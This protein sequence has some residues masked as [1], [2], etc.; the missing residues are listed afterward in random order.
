MTAS[1]TSKEALEALATARK[2]GKSYTLVFSSCTGLSAKVYQADKHETETTDDMKSE[3]KTEEV[4][5]ASG[6][7]TG[8]A[9]KI[10]PS[11][12]NI[13]DE[14]GE[15]GIDDINSG[16]ERHLDS[17]HIE[18]TASEGLSRDGE[19]TLK[20]EM[21]DEKFPTKVTLQPPRCSLFAVCRSKMSDDKRYT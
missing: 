9:R 19:V 12:G 21:Y 18:M 10:A 20:Y 5:R 2:R 4:N 15:K 8:A 14:G 13:V 16:E 6:N 17:R 1:T 11:E 7:A 3:E